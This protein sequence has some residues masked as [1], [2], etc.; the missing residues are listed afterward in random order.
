[1]GVTNRERVGKGLDLLAKGLRPFVERELKSRVG[2]NW[3]ASLP[4]ATPRPPA[5]SRS[6]RIWTIPRFF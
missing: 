3:Q 1:M 6:R 5:P 2:E 4:G